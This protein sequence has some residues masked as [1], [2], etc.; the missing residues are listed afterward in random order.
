MIVHHLLLSGQCGK[1]IVTLGRRYTN[2]HRYSGKTVTVR[3]VSR[4]K[5]EAGVE[6]WLLEDV[7]LHVILASAHALFSS[8]LFSFGE[9][10][11]KN[12]HLRS[13]N[14]PRLLFSY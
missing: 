1:V 6:R 10:G 11:K 12:L 14:L 2:R 5:T 3:K 9:W 8:F 13:K 4:T 7:P